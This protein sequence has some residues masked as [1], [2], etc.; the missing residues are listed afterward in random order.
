MNQIVRG[1]TQ[2]KDQKQKYHVLF[3]QGLN[4]SFFAWTNCKLKKKKPSAA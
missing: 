3:L 1:L 4:P 2:N